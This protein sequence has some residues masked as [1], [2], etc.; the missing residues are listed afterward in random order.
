MQELKKDNKEK[1]KERSKDLS[2]KD[3]L[4]LI[5]ANYR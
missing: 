3:L 5:I 2:K 1:T 4:N